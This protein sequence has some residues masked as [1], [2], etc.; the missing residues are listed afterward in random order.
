[1][2]RNARADFGCSTDSALPCPL[3]TIIAFVISLFVIGGIVFKMGFANPVGL[4][5][6]GL[7]VLTF[8]MW[9]GWFYWV[10][11]LLMVIALILGSIGRS[12][13]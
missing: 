10:I 5:L 1:M 6:V 8:F 13:G 7:G 11:W 9:V 3:T 2:F 4:M 12:V